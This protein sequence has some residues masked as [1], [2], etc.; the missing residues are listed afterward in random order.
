MMD[1]VETKIEGTSTWSV[2]PDNGRELE[3]T[4]MWRVQPDSNSEW[5]PYEA[6]V[7]TV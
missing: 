5:G 4:V 7:W 6:Q 1:N 3:I 2:D